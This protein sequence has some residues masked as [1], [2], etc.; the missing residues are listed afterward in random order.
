MIYVE[1]NRNA[2]VLLK[3]QL[4]A[5]GNV[6]AGLVC[7]V[8]LT[9]WREVNVNPVRGLDFCEIVKNT[10]R[11]LAKSFTWYDIIIQFTVEQ[12]GPKARGLNYT[13][14]AM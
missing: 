1:M 7:P 13:R 6:K 9:A 2:V 4:A 11:A 10:K 5:G 12:D 14:H 8:V 3:N